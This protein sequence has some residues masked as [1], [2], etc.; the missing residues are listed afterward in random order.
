M[1]N[2]KRLMAILAAGVLTAT[3]FNPAIIKAESV[4]AEEAGMA[5]PA[6]AAGMSVPADAAG[7]A[8]SADEAGAVVAGDG[9]E[10]AVFSED[11]TPVKKTV[12]AADINMKV[13]DSY[14]FPFLG[15]KAVLPEELKKQIENSDMLMITVLASSMPFSTGISLLR[16]RKT[17]M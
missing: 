17:K 10:T 12:K 14:D 11:G 2:K 4:S 1:M 16:S 13:Q 3:S 8:V 6:D 9:S 15:L 5:V 7:A